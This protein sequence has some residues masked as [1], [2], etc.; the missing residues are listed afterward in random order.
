MDDFLGVF[1]TWWCSGF[2]LGLIITTLC[3]TVKKVFKAVLQIS[4][5]KEV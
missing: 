5:D 1:I 3:C 2:G 4:L